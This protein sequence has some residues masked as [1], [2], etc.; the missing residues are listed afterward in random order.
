MGLGSTPF[1]PTVVLSHRT[2]RELLSRH[3]NRSPAWL[4]A[5]DGLYQGFLRWRPIPLPLCPRGG[6]TGPEHM[7]ARLPF[8]GWKWGRKLGSVTE[9]RDHLF[10]DRS[11]TPMVSETR[12][13]LKAGGKIPD[14][15]AHR[16]RTLCQELLT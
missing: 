5:P 3:N 7:S 8:T 13:D 14:K 2:H 11:V 9:V 6:G 16:A 1:P 10:L 15:E 4:R 12:V